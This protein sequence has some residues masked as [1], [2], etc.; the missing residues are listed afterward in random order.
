MHTQQ[1]LASFAPVLAAITGLAY[2]IEG[3]IVIRAPQPD[4][5][6]HASGYAVEAAFVIAL[7]ASIPIV[8]VLAAS[9]G[10]LSTVST[11]ITQLG[12]AG[13]LVSALPSLAIG[14]NTLGPAF[15]IGVLASLAGLLGLSVAALRSRGSGW[16]ASPLLLTGL[17]LSMALGNHGGGILFG[18]AWIGI[19]TTIRG[20]RAAPPIPATAV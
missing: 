3:A 18:I 1:R 8:P 9:A 2:M 12:F 14:G 10:R 19:S 5:H 15:L 17:V 6:W 16:W 7:A 13:M 11:R 20:R 4:S